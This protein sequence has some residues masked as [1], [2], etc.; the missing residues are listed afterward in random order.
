MYT[1]KQ[2]QQKINEDLKEM[3]PQQYLEILK[4]VIKE[5]HLDKLLKAKIRLILDTQS[6]RSDETGREL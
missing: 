4:E 5:P 3:T 6:P 1:G 2:I